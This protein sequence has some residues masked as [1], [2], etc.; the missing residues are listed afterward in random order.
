MNPISQGEININPISPLYRVSMDTLFSF[1]DVDCIGL[2][3]LIKK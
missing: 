1:T 2:P 3:V